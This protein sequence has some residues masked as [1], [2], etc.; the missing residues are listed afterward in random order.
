MNATLSSATVGLLEATT[1]STAIANNLSIS[2]LELFLLFGGGVLLYL[3]LRLIRW[4][5]PLL[6]IGPSLKARLVKIGPL[7]ELVV[8]MIYITSTIAWSLKGNP[9][10][11]M[12]ALGGLVVLVLVALWF[13]IR[14]YLSGVILRTESHIN[15]DDE[16]TVGDASGHVR[17]LRARGLEL[18]QAHGDTLFVPYR[19]VRDAMLLK[20]RR[21]LAV[22]RHTFV[23]NIP[24]NVTPT[25][26]RACIREATLLSHWISPSDAPRVAAIDHDRLEVTI[27]TLSDTHVA[28][29]ERVVREALASI[30]GAAMHG[31]SE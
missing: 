15:I 9:Q 16:V 2:P 19:H 23:V 18:E 29:V 8:W 7:A 11:R 26:A 27:Y 1:T 31:A 30:S 10:V 22:A 24:A 4:G 14:D 17:S 12:L 20:R 25:A 5:F 13:A 6:P 28:D 21:K 3:T